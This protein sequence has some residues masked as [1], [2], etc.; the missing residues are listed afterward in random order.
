MGNFLGWIVIIFIIYLIFKPK[1]NKE[2]IIENN[3]SKEEEIQDKIE[4]KEESLL[5]DI[6]SNHLKDYMQNETTLFECGRKNFIRLNE[7]FK[8]D[9]AKHGQVVKDWMDYMDIL[10]D[11]VHEHLMLDVSTSEESDEHWEKR[12]ELF[13][14]IQEIEKRFKE[15]LGDVYI[16]PFETMKQ[17]E[18]NDKIE[19]RDEKGNLIHFKIISE[20]IENWISYNESGQEIYVKRNHKGSL[21]EQWT[22]YDEH[23]KSRTIHNKDDK[24]YEY[25][26]KFNEKGE[27]VYC[28]DSTGFLRKND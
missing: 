12:Q 23:D 1:N 8:H 26:A 24:G 15:L 5:R 6:K 9:E 10:G 13:I 20:G 22:E 16:D 25:W 2:K 19:E 14:Q 18:K 27:E 28:K 11:I 4:R 7:R 3:M 21:S 17:N